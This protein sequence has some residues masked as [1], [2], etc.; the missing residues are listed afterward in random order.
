MLVTKLFR[1]NS[2]PIS[3]HCF[4]GWSIDV[5]QGHNTQCP[6]ESDGRL[7]ILAKTA[8]SYDIQ[9]SWLGSSVFIDNSAL[10]S[11]ACC[12][13][14][15]FLILFCYAGHCCK[16]DFGQRPNKKIHIL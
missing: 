5:K 7:R 14:M 3:P 8:F 6:S 12:N 4:P 1:V 11:T 15:C 13:L 2:P 9:S 16:G 10:M